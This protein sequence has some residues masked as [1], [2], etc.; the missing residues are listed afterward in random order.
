MYLKPKKSGSNLFLM[1]SIEVKGLN[2]PERLGGE[3]IRE[4][5]SSSYTSF[6]HP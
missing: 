4:F 3:F 2:L 6:V 5:S 1:P